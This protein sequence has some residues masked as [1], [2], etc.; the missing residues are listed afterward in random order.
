MEKTLTDIAK[1]IGA[2]IHGDRHAVIRGVSGLKE[3]KAGDLSFLANSRYTPL[4]NETRA[5]AVIVSKKEKY[6]TKVTLL[7]VENPSRAFSQVVSAMM[8]EEAPDSLR[9]IIHESAVI[10]KT[11]VLGKNVTIGPN[12]VIADDVHIGEGTVIGAGCFVGVRSHIGQGCLIHPN[13]SILARSLLGHRVIIHSGTVIGSDG[14]GFL[15]EDGA[16][17]KIPQIGIVQIDD[18]VEIGANVTIDRARFD[19]THIGA[20]TKIDNLVQIGHNV[21]IGK[22]CI[23]VALAG[24]SGSTVIE[25]GVVLAGQVGVA[26]HLTIGEGTVVAAQSG[27]TNAAPAKSVLFGSPALP[28]MKAKRINAALNRLPEYL[29]VIRDLQQKVNELERKISS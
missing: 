15:T 19:K 1:L 3:A 27:V 4:L 14:F 13:V 17:E 28:H 23:I 26:G 24:I 9:G 22:R 25:D 8:E 6:E 18:D 20:G 12:A 16:H 7:C 11:A 2:E 21:R 10:S 29:K 5:T